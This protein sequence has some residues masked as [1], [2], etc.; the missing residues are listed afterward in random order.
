[1]KSKHE[2]VGIVEAAPR[3]YPQKATCQRYCKE[4]AKQFAKLSAKIISG[5]PFTLKHY[6]SSA[7]IPYYFMG[8]GCDYALEEWIRDKKL[9]IIVVKS[10]S[11]LLKRHI[12]SLPK[13][14]TINIHSSL[15]PKYRGPNPIF[16]M[17][18]D[19]DLQGGVTVHHIDDGEDTGDILEQEMFSITVGERPLLIRR[20]ANEI[21]AMLLVKTLDRIAIGKQTRTPQPKESP[22]PRAKNVSLSEM[23]EFIDWENWSIERI[24][25]YFRYLEPFLHK[26]AG[27]EVAPWLSWKVV[28]YKNRDSQVIGETT[29][30]TVKTKRGEIYLSKTFHTAIQHFL[31]GDRKNDA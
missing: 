8:N 9:D 4:R 19:M 2:I 6:S 16:W 21:G 12:W 26:I 5:R 31:K 13:Y 18:H 20:K 7:Q 25:H 1:M 11:E 23:W 10:M 14:G 28:G 17:Y 27:W 3:G 30:I 22:T 29:K 24:F 15:L